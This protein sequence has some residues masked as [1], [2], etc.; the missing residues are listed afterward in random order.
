MTAGQLRERRK[1][2]SAPFVA[3]QPFQTEFIGGPVRKVSSRFR[4]TYTV[5]GAG[6]TALESAFG[7]G[8]RFIIAREEG[9]PLVDIDG[10][11][12]RQ[13]GLFKHG[14]ETLVLPIATTANGVLVAQEEVDFETFMPGCRID[15]RRQKI[16]R[17]GQYRAL[18]RLGSTVNGVTAQTDTTV[19]TGEIVGETYYEPL[20]KQGIVDCSSADTSRKFIYR[21]GKV[22]EY[23]SAMMI[24]Q[25]DFTQLFL[26]PNF[27]RCDGLVRNVKITLDNENGSKT[28]WD[29]PWGVL[30]MQQSTRHGVSRAELH[31]GVAMVFFDDPE[32]PETHEALELEPGDSITVELDTFSAVEDDFAA[33]T[34]AANDNCVLTFFSHTLRGAAAGEGGNELKARAVADVQKRVERKTTRIARRLRAQPRVLAQ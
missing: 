12:L 8:G 5:S 1:L 31:S 2:G 10:D 23:L 29:T 34:P 14:T 3:S 15:A 4:G 20:W 25:F 9:E 11:D 27:A 6:V 16:L 32:T 30:K 22:R 17:K 7:L 28:V 18:N 21:C 26:D 33:V 13:L 19:E 24:R